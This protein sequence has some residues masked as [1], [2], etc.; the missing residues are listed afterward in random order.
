[1]AEEAR[2]SENVQKPKS[3]F[4]IKAILIVLGVVFMEAGTV[5]FFKMFNTPKLSEGSN[6][7]EMTEKLPNEDM[8]ELVLVEEQ[9]VDNYTGSNTKYVVTLDVV[10]KVKSENQTKLKAQVEKHEKEV[11][12]AVREVISAAQLV[13]IK[14]P[15]T[16]VIRRSLRSRIEEII[17]EG[18][19]ETIMTPAFNSYPSD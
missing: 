14:D 6:G 5:T 13:E 1:M 7:I 11:E 19:I 3:K 10:A 12:N 9:N 16:E 2:G 15:H 4:P 18:M 17:G 8:V